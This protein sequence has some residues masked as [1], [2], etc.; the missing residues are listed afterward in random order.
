MFAE[1]LEFA[2]W[3]TVEEAMRFWI[4]WPRTWFSERNFKLSSLTISTLWLKS[5]KKSVCWI[6]KWFYLLTCFEVPEFEQS[7][8]LFLPDLLLLAMVELVLV[9]LNCFANCLES[10]LKKL[11]SYQTMIVNIPSSARGKS[12]IFSADIFI[13]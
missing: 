3:K 2:G 7:T 6:Y 5:I 11:M 4:Y 10:I 9:S 13:I 12:S 8:G 1:V